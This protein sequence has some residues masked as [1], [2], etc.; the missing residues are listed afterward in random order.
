MQKPAAFLWDMDGT[1]VNSDP[2]WATAGRELLAAYDADITYEQ[3]LQMVGVSLWRAAE[4]MQQFG[5]DLPAEEI[6]KRKVS[7][8][9]ELYKEQGANWLPGV[10]ETLAQ[11]HAAGVPNVMVTMAWTSIGQAVADLLPAGTFHYVLGGD[12]VTNS[13]PHPEPYLL[14]AQHAGAQIQDC[15]AFEDSPSGI[16]AAAASGAVTIGLRN[17]VPIDHCPAHVIVDSLQPYSI[18]TWYQV[19]A[20]YR[21]TEP[22]PGG[23]NQGAAL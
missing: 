14:G 1:L 8:V 18:D 21:G 11:V 5:V 12:Q 19:F 17:L 10:R 2:L 9:L 16:N 15:I 6:I 7:R 20:K 4:I 13:K 23:H 22:V 3:G